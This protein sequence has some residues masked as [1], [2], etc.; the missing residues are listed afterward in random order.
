MNNHT[1]KVCPSCIYTYTPFW[2]FT[3]IAHMGHIQT[4]YKYSLPNQL[5]NQFPFRPQP[6]YPFTS[7]DSVRSLLPIRRDLFSQHIRCP[8]RP[9]WQSIQLI[10]HFRGWDS[11]YGYAKYWLVSCIYTCSINML[12]FHKS[13]CVAP[14]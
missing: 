1:R 8:L 4:I 12:L 13:P 11:I 3:D 5:Y 10:Y 6:N 2:L 14:V 7:S 9:K